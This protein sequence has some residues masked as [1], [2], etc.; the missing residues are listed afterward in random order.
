MVNAPKVYRSF[1]DVREVNY[2]CLSGDKKH[3]VC[4]DGDVDAYKFLVDS[5]SKSQMPCNIFGYAFIMATRYNY[6]PA[7]YDLYIALDKAYGGYEHLNDEMKYLALYFLK[8]GVK[9]GDKKCIR[10]IKMLGLKN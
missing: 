6:T 8:R 2:D 5:I 3:A 10:Q 4:E 9:E 7:N 1:N